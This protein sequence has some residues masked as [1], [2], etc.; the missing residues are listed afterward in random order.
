MRKVLDWDA[1]EDRA[2]RMTD[3]ELHYARIDAGKTAKLWDGGDDPDGNS[4]FYR[5]EAS[6]YAREQD[7]R[8]EMRKSD[9]ARAVESVLRI[10]DER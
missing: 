4:G 3:S 8:R 10:L 5:D 9:G 1:T 6:V 7:R 2:R